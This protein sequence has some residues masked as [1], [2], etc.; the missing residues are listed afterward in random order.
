MNPVS[1]LVDSV[2]IPLITFF[3]DQIPP[4]NYGLAIVFLTLAVKFALY[5]LA[6]RQFVNMRQ[7]QRLQP[8]LKAMQDEFKAKQQEAKDQAEKLQLQQEFTARMTGFYKEHNANP[9]SGCLTLVIQLPVLWALYASLRSP[10]LIERLVSPAARTFLFI[11]DLLASGIN[12]PTDLDFCGSARTLATGLVTQSTKLHNCVPPQVPLHLHI[13]ASFHWDNVI[14]IALFTVTSYV[15]QRM[16]T[17]NP[18]DPMQ[19]QMLIMGPLMGPLIGWALPSGLLL[20]FVV[21]GLFTVGQYFILLRRFPAQPVAAM[22]P[23]GGSPGS[24]GTTI[25]V[26]PTTPKASDDGGQVPS[27]KNR[28]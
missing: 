19:R 21:S 4:H 2:M 28:R 26:R 10:Q 24:S 25:E 6:Q 16:M 8:M 3:H 18:N 23:T 1:Y 14:L 7:M 9:A 5:P 11:K 15:T 12:S 13:A 27:R 17:T 20:Y 22:P